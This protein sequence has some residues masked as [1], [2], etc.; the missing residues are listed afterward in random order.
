MELLSCYGYLMMLWYQNFSVEED[1]IPPMHREV[2]R[3]FRGSNAD[4]ERCSKILV[5]TYLT[6]HLLLKENGKRELSFPSLKMAEFFAGLYLGRY[7]DDCVI[8]ELQPE[9]GGGEW[10]NVWRFVA[11]LPETTNSSGHSACEPDSLCC[12]LQALFAV[13]DEGKVRPTESMFRAWQV[14]QRNAWLSNVRQQVLGGWRQQFRRILIEGYDKRQPTER[15]RTAAEVLLKED[16]EQ[17]VKA[18]KEVEQD[19]IN[20]R[21]RELDKIK[22]PTV[23]EKSELETLSA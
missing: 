19:R 17:F 21:L 4:W 1:K 16:L 23:Q 14:L 10:N 9:I 12:S 8:K 11:E 5:D 13:P 22:R 18:G 7:S 6:E 20:Q 15:A 3:R 2:K